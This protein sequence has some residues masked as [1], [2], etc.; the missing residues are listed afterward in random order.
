MKIQTEGKTIQ[1]A[2]EEAMKKLQITD[3]EIVE[4]NII[5]EETKGIFGFGSKNALVEAKV[6]DPVLFFAKEFLTG[7]L[8]K[9]NLGHF[10]LDIETEGKDKIINIRISIASKSLLIG[11]YGKTLNSLEYLTKIYI[12]RKFEEYDEKPGKL[13]LYLDV[14][15]YRKEKL[16]KL[17]S[18]ANRLAEKVKTTGK[19]MEMKPMTARERKIIHMNFK[20]DPAIKTFSKGQDPFRKVVLSTKKK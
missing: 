15:D 5:E 10:D 12:N 1:L 14:E 20:N 3:E 8:N 9:M 2:K 6:K 19:S 7:L 13:N 17:E 18:I 16:E 4:F 11:R